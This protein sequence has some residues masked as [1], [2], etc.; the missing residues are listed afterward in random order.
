[1][2]NI[3]LPLTNQLKEFGA[4]VV[5][6]GKSALE[7]FGA[8]GK[9][10]FGTG[11]TAITAIL[12]P[13]LAIFNQLNHVV[14]LLT[15]VA[16]VALIS[17][18]MALG[19]VA[20]LI[21]RI[22]LM[23]S[24]LHS[25]IITVTRG[26][27]LL[28]LRSMSAGQMM[29]SAV[30]SAGISMQ[31]FGKNM[32]WAQA[33]QVGAVAALTAITLL[34]Q[35]WD[36]AGQK[37]KKTLE[38]LKTVKSARPD[39][40]D[41]TLDTENSLSDIVTY[42]N[43]V[44]ETQAK[45][46][47]ELEKESGSI[48][49]KVATAA[50]GPIG[51]IATAFGK[52][53][54]EGARTFVEA[55][56]P[57]DERMAK[58]RQT[59]THATDEAKKYMSTMGSVG[60]LQKTLGDE[61][62]VS[63][64]MILRAANSMGIDLSK[65]ADLSTEELDGLK[66]TLSGMNSNMLMMTFGVKDL[67]DVSEEEFKNIAD[68][69]EKLHEGVVEAF[70]GMT[71][72]IEAFE[73]S[74]KKASTAMEIWGE[75]TDIVREEAKTASDAM[76]EA[77]KEASED[78]I[79]AL[80][81]QKQAE[82]DALTRGRREAKQAAGG[83]EDNQDAVD[84]ITDASTA[85]KRAIEDRYDAQIEAIRDGSDAAAQAQQ[86]ADSKIFPSAD[87][88]KVFAEQQ[89]QDITDYNVKLSQV[90]SMEGFDAENKK[91][92]IDFLNSMTTEE[93]DALMTEIL[94]KGGTFATDFNKTLSEIAKVSVKPNMDAVLGELD[95][96]MT[97]AADMQRNMVTIMTELGMMGR[98][99][100]IPI[101]QQMV[102]ELGPEKASA[103]LAALRESGMN[104]TVS[105]LDKWSESGVKSWDKIVSDMNAMAS[106][107]IAEAQGTQ[108]EMVVA[109]NQIMDPNKFIEQLSALGLDEA[110][111]QKYKDALGAALDGATVE[112]QARWSLFKQWLAEQELIFHIKATAPGVTD[113]EAA[114]LAGWAG[115]TTGSGLG[116]AS[117]G[118]INGPRL[119]GEEGP[120]M[121][122]P[123]TSGFII[124]NQNLL[125]GMNQMFSICGSSTQ[126]G[127][128]ADSMGM[129]PG[130][131]NAMATGPTSISKTSTS[132]TNFYGGIQGTNLNE[133]IR[134]AERKKRNSNL[135]AGV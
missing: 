24:T 121:F 102:A 92:L 64:D 47:E 59:Y 72:P 81:D 7:T 79:K 42:Y 23:F 106:L 18:F 101:F 117:G 80:E 85:E 131:R 114:A 68:E 71:D 78:R 126:S 36:D 10:S 11:L 93:S 17:K 127:S 3:L 125:K 87:R 1:V 104:T 61:F 45:A 32:N 14:V 76:I 128:R 111:V 133:V 48:F 39:Q 57:L 20:A 49:N 5:D 90:L 4:T 73:S 96:M 30:R 118:P 21:S 115:T 31:N 109:I 50:A 63:N 26:M 13:I 28:G 52:D 51:T 46:G 89:L 75:L 53:I 56:T 29:Q 130:T 55:V 66:Q 54:G 67:S 103:A 108:G 95:G 77:D 34:Q 110:T 43:R 65:G 8:I 100:L 84:E 9:I 124:S 37:A 19:P 12:T 119:V 82:M 116:L 44:V 41:R 91:P 86:D 83:G 107:L 60:T 98:A 112:M 25:G 33:I 94:A 120:E 105:V 99:D 62:S 129:T 6:T 122:M 74:V 15:N 123:N 134:A 2:S 135:G 69:A 97:E 22:G 58:L 113:E 16:I 27:T 132:S 35:A 40:E 38:D 70:S 88:F